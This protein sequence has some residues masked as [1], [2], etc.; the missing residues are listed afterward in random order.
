MFWK[1]LLNVL[2]VAW[3]GKAAPKAFARVAVKVPSRIA[4]ILLAAALSF[5][6]CGCQ[7]GDTDIALTSGLSDEEVF[8]IGDTTCTL[9]K[10][11]IFLTNYQN[12]YG[13]AYGIN[14]WEHDFGDDSL[15]DYIKDLTISQL[16]R[17]ISMDYLAQEQEIALDDTELAHIED[18]AEAYYGSLSKDEIAYMDVDVEIIRE[19]Y[20]QYGLADKLYQQLTTGVDNE[21]SDDEARI[22]EAYQIFVTDKEDADAISDGLADGSDFLTLA[23]SY[24][25]ADRTEITFG[26]GELPENVEKASFAL[27]ADEIA[28]PLETDEGY[29]FIKCID[30]YN[31][32][33]TD[34]NKQVILERRRKEAFDDVYEAFVATLPSEFN[35]ALWDSIEVRADESI[36]TNSFFE[37]YENYVAH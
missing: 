19:L 8:R 32:E 15:E 27:D 14:L 17:I 3:G 13:T 37:V 1:K 7:V 18:A 20:Q 23:G 34:A 26:K 25:K 22:M 5:G 33:L 21:V 36:K 2:R 10:A 29:Y 11:R 28:G 31:Q 4:A 35:E 12:L 24:N 9:P 30:N 16:A 6:L